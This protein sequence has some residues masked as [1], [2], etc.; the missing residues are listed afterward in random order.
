M[1]PED[2]ET[3]IEI[4][5]EV[6]PAE[7]P[8]MAPVLT[9][10][11]RRP[12]V[13]S[14]ED[15]PE[16][17]PLRKAAEAA[18]AYAARSQAHN[19]V[20]AYKS[21]W[22]HFEQWCISRRAPSMP[23]TPEIVALYI[24]EIAQG[25]WRGEEPKKA[26]T[27]LRRLAAINACHKRECK[28]L[29]ASQKY[30]EISVVLQGILRTEGASQVAKRPITLKMADK[31]LDQ[32]TV[33]LAAARD[34]V[35]LLVGL[36]GAFRRSELAGVAMEH[37]KF[38]PNGI[39]VTIPVSKTDQT[40]K[41]RE[42]EIPYGTTPAT[43]PVSAVRNWI[44]ASAIDGKNGPLLR[45]VDRNG[46]VRSKGMNP[47]SIGYVI[48]KLAAAAGYN[49]EDYAGHSLRAGFVTAA[50]A[51]G[52][53]DRQIMRQTGHKSRQMIDRYSRRDQLDRQEAAGK[54]GF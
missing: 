47:A 40:G 30:P 42:V 33:P 10:A 16:D 52:A 14:V 51:G 7:K 31:M 18:R 29:P 35:I 4:A 5:G 48:K 9:F 25:G 17:D 6:L 41:G 11:A 32:E 8:G 37:L 26:A 43:C 49:A 50:A 15:L 3:A 28:F 12:G 1:S 19:T 54:V 13:L 46:C 2:S 23:S 39:T 45:A 20:N 22:E 27:I 53:T 38:H 34:K 24:A 36:A 44:A 21:D